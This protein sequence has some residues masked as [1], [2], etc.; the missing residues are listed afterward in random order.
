MFKFA[1]YKVKTKQQNKN[2]KL[3][4]VP[5]CLNTVFGGNQVAPGATLFWFFYRCGTNTDAG[6]IQIDL[7]NVRYS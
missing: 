2:C 7:P 4:V 3:A 6:P 1:L 5:P